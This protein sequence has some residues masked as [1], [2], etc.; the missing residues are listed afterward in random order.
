MV[1]QSKLA[2]DVSAAAA[3][4][5]RGSLLYADDRASSMALSGGFDVA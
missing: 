5:G 3:H 1:A 4:G 2:V